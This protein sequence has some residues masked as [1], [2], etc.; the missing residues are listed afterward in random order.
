MQNLR[1]IILAEMDRQDF[2]RADVDRLLAKRE[3]RLC[4]RSNLY[5]FLAGS[6]LGY[7]KIAELFVV[8]GLVVLRK[9]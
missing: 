1:K 6:E 9:K 7:E 8:L 2:S 4:S 5:K 3:P